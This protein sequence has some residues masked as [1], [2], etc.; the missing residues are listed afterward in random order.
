MCCLT[1][2]HHG[3]FRFK[4]G[5]VSVPGPGRVLACED[6]KH[7]LFVPEA[8]GSD[9]GSYE[10]AS[11]HNVQQAAGNGC[12]SSDKWLLAEVFDILSVD[13]QNWFGTLCVL[14]WLLYLIVL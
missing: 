9:D 8:S 14:L 11:H 12:S 10:A 3:R 13:W 1:S 6:R 4:D 7:F 2:C 5:E